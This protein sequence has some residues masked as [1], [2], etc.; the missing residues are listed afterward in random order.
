MAWLDLFFFLSWEGGS[1]PPPPGV[2]HGSRCAAWPPGFLAG[3]A[4]SSGAQLILKEE[5]TVVFSF[6][7]PVPGAPPA[8][9]MSSV[10]QAVTEVGASLGLRLPYCLLAGFLNSMTSVTHWPG[11]FNI[12][13]P[14]KST[15]C[16]SPQGPLLSVYRPHLCQVTEQRLPLPSPTVTTP[17]TFPVSLDLPTLHLHWSHTHT[18]TIPI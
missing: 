8:L 17:V 13:W 10:G 3:V 11:L 9:C 7:L 14:F 18:H 2:T 6:L 1:S 12:S 16:P 5:G 15:P 4:G